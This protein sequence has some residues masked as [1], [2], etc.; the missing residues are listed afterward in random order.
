MSVLKEICQKKLLYVKSQEKIVS[1]CE[2]KEKAVN[3]PA[4]R[5]FLKALEQKRGKALIAE[6]KKKSPSKGDLFKDANPPKIA[7]A[8]EE[9]GACCI[10]VL[11]DAP[12]FGGCDEDFTNARAACSIPMLRKDFM[13]TPYQIYESRALGADCILLIMAALD[14]KTA[15]ELYETAT[16]LGM[17]ALIETHNEDEIN[18]AIKMKAQIIGVNSRNLKTLEVDLNTASKM[19]EKLKDRAFAIAESGINDKTSIKNFAHQGYGGFLVGEALMCSKDIKQA[20][21]EILS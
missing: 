16:S 3:T 13:L 20:T 14:D 17:D 15:C 9:G 8:Y 10:S 4:P 1:L 5:G 19:A 21:I 12:Y 6:I 18:R 7:K 2:I 11:T